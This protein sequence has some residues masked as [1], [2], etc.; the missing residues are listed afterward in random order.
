MQTDDA[1]A[2]IENAPGPAEAGAVAAGAAGPRFRLPPRTLLLTV[3]GGLVLLVALIF[4]VRAFVGEETAPEAA[5]AGSEETAASA[6]ADRP[7]APSSPAAVPA[8]PAENL[9]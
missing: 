2:D 7:K 6:G 9:A 4:G 5:S 3:L 1:V 8:D